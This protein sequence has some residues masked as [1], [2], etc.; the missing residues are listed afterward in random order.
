MPPDADETARL[1]ARIRQLEYERAC[2][3][4]YEIQARHRLAEL[5]AAARR[6]SGALRR[7]RLAAH[8]R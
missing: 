1:Q 8:D 6:T 5:Q 7:E 2:Y 4:Q 3:R